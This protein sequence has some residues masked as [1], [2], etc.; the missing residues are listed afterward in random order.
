MIL[1]LSPPVFNLIV[2]IFLAIQ[3]DKAT[4]EKKRTANK[5]LGAEQKLLNLYEGFQK[6]QGGV[7]AGI[8]RTRK[9]S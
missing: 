4:E 2:I 5:Q 9:K 6:I 7:E 1:L 8:E 3:L